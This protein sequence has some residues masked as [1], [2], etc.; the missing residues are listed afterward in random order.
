MSRFRGGRFVFVLCALLLAAP[1]PAAAEE[2]AFPPDVP[3]GAALAPAAD[4]GR[5]TALD[6]SLQGAYLALR[7][8]DW[9]Q[10]REVAKHPE[11]YRETLRFLGD[12]PSPGDVNRYMA[13]I[14]VAHAGIS[15]YLDRPYRTAWQAVT[16]F[17][18][19]GATRR[20][21]RLGLCVSISF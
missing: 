10:T 15:M 20:N 21:H 19:Y 13:A 8:I 14:A 9:R 5:W 7:Y 1:V 12:H 3:G 6:F 18:V 11:L 4:L 17:E 2:F 16:L